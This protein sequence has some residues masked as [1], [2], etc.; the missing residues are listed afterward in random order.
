MTIVHVIPFLWSGAGKVLTRLCLSQRRDA[1]VHVVTSSRSSG[2]VDWPAY[3]RQLRAGGVTLHRVDSFDRSSEAVWTA[4]DQLTTLIERVRPTLVHAHAGAP[5]VLCELAR[6]R[7]TGRRVPLVAHMYS[8]GP[9]RPHW[10]NVMDLWGLAAADATICS[11][12][13]YM[14][15][16]RD[17]GVAAGRLHYVPWGIEP[18]PQAALT[19][20]PPPVPLRGGVLG[21]VGRIEPR[22]NQLALVQAFRYVVQQRPDA[23]LE[24]IG[25]VADA[26]YGRKVR[27]R[28][29]ELGLE[30]H[31]RLRGRVVAVWPHLTALDLLVS[32]SDDE[33]QGLAILEA[34]AVGVPVAAL[35]VSGVEDYLTDGRTGHVVPRRTARGVAASLLAAL[36]DEARRRRMAR[37]GLRLVEARYLWP[38]TVKQIAAIYRRVREGA[39]RR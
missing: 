31:V 39:P 35:R 37:G 22:K 2:E 18:P 14:T 8:W 38:R 13:H 26:A 27:D 33:G 1:R 34:M 6:R 23:R 20:A 30:R 10:M 29:V 28:I 36:D 12:Q 17:G 7:A 19:P 32:L 24:L 4:V 9:G 3:R 25:P 21:C 16:L 15:V 5:A 11:A